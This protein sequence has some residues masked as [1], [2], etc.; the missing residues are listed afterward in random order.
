MK[1]LIVLLL[2]SVS[3]FAINAQQGKYVIRGTI[4]GNYNAEKV[5]LVEEEFINGPQTVIDSC[6]VVDGKYIF[7]GIVPEFVKI[8]FVKGANPEARTALTP[9]FLEEGNINVSNASA[10]HFTH[11]VKVRGTVNNDLLSF[12]FF[13]HGF[14]TDS[15]GYA[16]DLDWRINGYNSDN[17][18]TEFPRRT[19]L[20]MSRWLDIQKSMVSKFKD[21]VFA[22]F[23]LYWEMRRDLTP[24]EFKAYRSLLDPKLDNHPYTKA[25]DD[26]ITSSEFGIGNKMP[27]FKMPDKNDN[28][29]EW[30]EFSGKYVLIDFWAS[31][32]GPCLRE[33]PNVVKLYEECKGDNFEIVGISLDENK[34]KWLNTVEE[35]KM[36][37]PQL[38]D[39]KAWDS[40]IVKLCNVDAVPTTVLV[41]PD[42]NVVAINLRGEALTEKIKEL[43]SQ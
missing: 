4:S 36:T 43:I 9:V 19:K 10:E 23:M 33:M 18:Q 17:E 13:Q 6:V 27:D 28:V 14:I 37:W 38:C 39:F 32:C 35:Y 25:I 42:G 20:T 8:Y 5:Y 16:T 12:Y 2:L 7:E 3:V 29:V 31:W 11:N 24:G 15:I 26:F 22:P 41:S 21:Q 1:K 30:K 34:E 40:Q